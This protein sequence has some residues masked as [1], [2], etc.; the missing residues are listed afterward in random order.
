ME[1]I[2]NSFETL[3]LRFLVFRRIED[4]IVQ[5][6]IDDEGVKVEDVVKIKNPIET[7]VTF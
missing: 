2:E 4:Q 1:K 7:T 6:I 3:I 5:K